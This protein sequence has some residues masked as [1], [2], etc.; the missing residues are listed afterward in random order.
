[1]KLPLS[2]FLAPPLA[3]AWHLPPNCQPAKTSR[4]IRIYFPCMANLNSWQQKWLI[5]P[6]V[7]T[8]LTCVD[9]R[10]FWAQ[11][12]EVWVTEG[13]DRSKLLPIGGQDFLMPQRGDCLKGVLSHKFLPASK[14]LH[15]AGTIR[16]NCISNFLPS[17]LS[18]WY[19]LPGHYGGRFWPRKIWEIV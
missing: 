7:Y 10:L 1:M 11:D 3:F 19:G 12:A 9:C 4:V 2:L 15:K 8:A 18:G 6:S 14:T 17:V 16:W 13:P 5:P